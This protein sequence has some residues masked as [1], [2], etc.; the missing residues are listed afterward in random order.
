MKPGDS[1]RQKYVASKEAYDCFTEVFA[2]RNPLHTD[3]AYAKAHG[4]DGLV[5]HGNI[6]NCFLSHFIGERLP[7]RNVMILSQQIHFNKPVYLSQEVELRADV[8]CFH[9]SVKVYEMKFVFEDSAGKKLA[10]GSFQIGVI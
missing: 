8:V 10:K 4:F 7:I 2:D 9:E 5:M 3:E 6:L 1:F